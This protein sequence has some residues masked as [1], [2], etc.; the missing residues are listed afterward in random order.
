MIDFPTYLSSAG[1]TNALAGTY[2]TVEVGTA[3]VSFSSTSAVNTATLSVASAASTG[4]AT[5]TA[6]GSAASGTATKS[7]SSAIVKGVDGVVAM[8]VA[9]AMGLVFA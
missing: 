8:F 1:F 4:T 7:A 6:T 9:V 3:T 2:F 5:G